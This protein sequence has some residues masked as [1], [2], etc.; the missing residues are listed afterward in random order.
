VNMQGFHMD[1]DTWQ[2][3]VGAGTKLAQVTEKLH[4]A[5]GRAI[6]HGVC[7]G[8]GIGGHA[9][10]GG[11]GPMSRMWGTCLDHVI[12]VEV[13]TAD[14]VIRRA[15]E[16]DNSDLFWVSSQY[17]A[18]DPCSVGFGLNLLLLGPERRR[19]ELRCHYRVCREDAPRARQCG[20]VYIRLHVR[21]TDGHGAGVPRLAG[22]HIGPEP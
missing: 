9:T 8:V 7:P 22:S 15:N 19:R 20:A 17:S 5:G 16:V 3:R 18:L 12:E 21:P 2:A 1:N 4:I 6:A 14:G 13:V 10:I 11:L